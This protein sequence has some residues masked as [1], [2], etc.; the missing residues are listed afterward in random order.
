MEIR[1]SIYG[2][3]RAPKEAQPSDIRQPKSESMEAGRRGEDTPSAWEQSWLR[4]EA[5]LM[6]LLRMAGKMGK[7]GERLHEKAIEDAW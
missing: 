4:G 1:I 7:G 6:R 3:L 5:P 2:A